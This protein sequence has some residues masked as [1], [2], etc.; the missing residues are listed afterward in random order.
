VGDG[1]SVGNMGGFGAAWAWG[2][3][4]LLVSNPRLYFSGLSFPPDAIDLGIRKDRV[5]ST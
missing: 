1:D 3:R 4:S 5:I 2:L